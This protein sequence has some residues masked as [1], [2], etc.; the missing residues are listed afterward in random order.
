MKSRVTTYS[1]V[2]ILAFFLLTGA[3][4][5]GFV[6]GSVFMAPSQQALNLLPN[7]G[8]R[9]ASINTD[10]DRGATP[11]ELQDLFVPYWQAWDLVHEQYVDQP[12]DDELLMRGAIRGMMDS[13][14]DPHTSY[15]DPVLHEQLTSQL[16][17]S[18]EYEGIGAWVNISSD[19]LTIISPMPDSPAEKAGLRTGDMIIAV[20]GDDM[21]GV[22]GEMVRQRLMGPKGTP[23]IL[24]VHR[25][26]EEPF[27][28]EIVRASITVPSVS[29]K[30][31]DEGNIAYLRIYIFSENVSDD[32]RDT[33]KE[34]MKNDPDGLIL[35]LRGNG[36]GFLDQSIEVASEFIGDGVI[37]YEEYGDGSRRTFEAKRGGTATDIPLVVL[38]NEGSASAS[39]IVAG[40]IQD[41]GR[42]QLVGATSFGK[43][44]V[45]IPNQLK[46]EQGAVRITV[47]R[48]LTPNERTIH[49]IGL[50]PDFEVEIT[51]ENFQNNIDPQLDKAIELLLKR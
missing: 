24:T 23:V 36:G 15:L 39:E 28:V 49:E 22:D 14:G 1:I 37:L 13:L 32:L 10:A 43:G 20:D 17:G 35:D 44:S 11:E 7:L 38:I 26:G 29:G 42:G 46:N 51:E 34:L 6:A 40:A 48:W 12:V 5:I 45:Q 19:Y 2:G 41:R 18:E 3:C 25:E 8:D 4:A 30:M 47:A 31:L 50:T 21:T 16:E 9:T 33:L 27:D